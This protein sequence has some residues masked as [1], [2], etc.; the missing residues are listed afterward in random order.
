MLRIL[1]VFI[2]TA[3]LSLVAAPAMA[4]EGS[5]GT[6]QGQIEVNFTSNMYSQTIDFD[7]DDFTFG[8]T[9]ID[10][11]AGYM[12]TDNI[13]AGLKLILTSSSEEWRGTTDETGGTY[14]YV[15]ASYNHNMDGNIT[16]FVG[17]GVGTDSYENAESKTAERTRYGPFI[18]A[19]F[20]LSE[21]AAIN[22]QATYDIITYS[23]DDS[24]D[25]D[26]SDLNFNLGLSVFFN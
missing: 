11:T 12:F 23:Y 20:F 8:G 4:Q 22:F 14:P 21:W 24:D 16:P 13:Q 3:A 9:R 26:G 2:F 25:Y 15:F 7:G 5:W 10:V 6:H 18:G 19:K 17:V 1:S